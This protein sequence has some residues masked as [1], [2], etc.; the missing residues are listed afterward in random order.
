MELKKASL[1]GPRKEM[2]L[3]EQVTH[4]AEERS[5]LRILARKIKKA[6]LKDLN[7][8]GKIISQW[9]ERNRMEMHELDSSDSE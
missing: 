6:H 4:V 7:I 3:T 2:G 1:L 8:D 9:S 5:K